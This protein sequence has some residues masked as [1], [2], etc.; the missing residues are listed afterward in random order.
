MLTAALLTLLVTEAVTHGAWASLAIGLVAPDLALALACGGERDLE[1]GQLHP[2]AVGIYNVVHRFW[3]PLALI[4]VV[5]EGTL[6]AGWFVLGVAW[7]T[8][9]ALDRSVGDGLRDAR[10]FQRAR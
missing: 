5:V 6:G 7:A 4:A 1:P 10:G 9:I 8:H 2:R 3:G